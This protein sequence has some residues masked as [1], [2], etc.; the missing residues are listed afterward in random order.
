MAKARNA[1]KALA[2]SAVQVEIRNEALPRSKS[3]LAIFV[4]GKEVAAI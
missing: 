2:A 1:A 3:L 4:E